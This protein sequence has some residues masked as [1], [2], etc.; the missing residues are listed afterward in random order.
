MLDGSH[1]LERIQLETVSSS[2]LLWQLKL[3]LS[4]PIPTTVWAALNAEEQSRCLRYR[5]YADQVRFACTRAALRQLLAQSLPN[6]DVL[7]FAI[8]IHGK[9]YLLTEHAPFLCR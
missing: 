9:P 6:L 1:G 2:V 3:A 4:E 7:S 5:Q 8:G